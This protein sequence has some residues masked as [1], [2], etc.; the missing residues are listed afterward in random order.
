[1]DYIT[2]CLHSIGQESVTWEAGKCSLTGS[3]GRNGNGFGEQLGNFLPQLFRRG[4]IRNNG[5]FVSSTKRA[6]F[7]C[8]KRFY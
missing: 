8:F 6:S 1:M 7:Y 5:A 4:N 3:Q 2:A